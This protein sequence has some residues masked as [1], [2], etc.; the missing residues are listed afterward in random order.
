MSRWLALRKDLTESQEHIHLI[1][2]RIR[3]LYGFGSNAKMLEHFNLSESFCSQSIG[4]GSIPWKLIDSVSQEKNISLDY[5]V[6]GVK[7]TPLVTFE[8]YELAI[9]KALF[10]AKLFNVLKSEKEAEMLKSLILSAI[11]EIEPDLEESPT[12]PG[13][14][15]LNSA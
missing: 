2:K 9:S 3:E 11:G 12:E 4:R 7:V 10:K 5:L 14:S 1:F 6:Y 15:S 8:K 13:F